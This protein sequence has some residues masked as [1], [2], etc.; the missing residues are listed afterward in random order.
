MWTTLAPL[1]I[2]LSVTERAEAFNAWKDQRAVAE[3]TRSL[4]GGTHVAPHIN[5]KD[6][7]KASRHGSARKRAQS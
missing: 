2:N 3:K 7:A 5:H 1:D 4:C 6:L